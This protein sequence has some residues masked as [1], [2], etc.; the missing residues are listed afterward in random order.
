MDAVAASPPMSTRD[1]TDDELIESIRDG[2]EEAFRVLVN[3]YQPQ[4]LRLARLYVSSDATA[5]EVAQETWIAVL[6]GLEK[7]EGRGSFRSWLF[8]I[9]TNQARR[10]GTRDARQV[11][12]ASTTRLIDDHYQ[13][14]VDSTRLKP[15]SDPVEPL[16]WA[17]PPPRWDT[18]PE[19]R[20][21]DS[22]LRAVLDHSIE[23]LSP[24]QRE[25]ITLRDI[26]GWESAETA[27]ALGISETNQRVLLHRARSRVRTG[28]EDYFTS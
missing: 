16:H 6:R 3:N 8:K 21:L 2:D 23:A 15:A 28:L 14:A 26:L 18:L 24:S 13:G 20:L 10:R 4:L 1:P 19:P 5:A 12:F 22:E 9:L 17:S 7:F 11:P 25:V 27:D